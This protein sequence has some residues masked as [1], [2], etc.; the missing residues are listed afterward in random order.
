MNGDVWR[1]KPAQNKERKNL[2]M[3]AEDC[4]LCSLDALNGRSLSNLIDIRYSSKIAAN[5]LSR[6][7]IS[8][9]E[10]KER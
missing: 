6:Q 1:G 10:A 3:L 5:Y 2:Q 4:S 8:F 9:F 7:R